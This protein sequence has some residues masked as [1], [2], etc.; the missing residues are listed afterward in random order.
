MQT[1]SR[2]DALVAA[3]IEQNPNH[4]GKDEARLKNYGV[5]VWAIIGYWKASN[6]DISGT[7]AGYDVPI[8]AVEAA[9]AY[10]ERY[11]VI[12]DNRL[13]ANDPDEEN[14]LR[15]AL[16]HDPDERI[17]RWLEPDLRHLGAEEVRLRKYGVSVWAIVD[18]YHT[19]KGDVPQAAR[20]YDVPV[21]AIQAAI[22]YYQ[23]NKEIIDNRRAA[24]YPEYVD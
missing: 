16:L 1:Q 2:S 23:R 7:A 4:L 5:S 22:I 10:Y 12:I 20:E 18:K 14:Q 6:G 21:E 8:E 24:N 9:V 13:A 17:R 15:D 19:F 11:K 3:Y